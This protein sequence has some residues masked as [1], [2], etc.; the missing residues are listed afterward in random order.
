MK[1][2]IL[3]S[4][5][6]GVPAFA[7]TAPHTCEICAEVDTLATDWDATKD[8]VKVGELSKHSNEL[9][10]KL[11]AMNKRGINRS[12]VHAMVEVLATIYIHDDDPLDDELNA[13][14]P[15]FNKRPFAKLFDEEMGKLPSDKKEKLRV[16]ITWMQS[17]KDDD[18]LDFD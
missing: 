10:S 13:L 12:V 7:A 16:G 4:L 11:T 8:P 3:V 9:L 15:A 17:S 6:V 5:F 2:A 14:R 18:E 1:Y